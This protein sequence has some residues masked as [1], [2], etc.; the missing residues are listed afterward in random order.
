[1]RIVCVGGGPAGLYVAVLMKRADPTHEITVVERNP[2]GFSHGWGVVF[3]HPLLELLGASDPVTAEE[4]A[5]AAFAW[6]GQDVDVQGRGR[7]S[8]PSGGFSIARQHLLDILTDRARALGVHVDFDRDVSPGEAF[9]ADLVVAADGAN[10]RHR[11]AGGF[12]AQVVAGRNKYVWLATSKVFTSFLFA[13]VE[14]PAG[15]LWCHAYGYDHDRSTVIVECSPTTWRGLGLDRL[16]ARES[17]S[18]LEGLFD[19]HLDGHPLIGPPTEGSAPLPW[20]EFR[21]VRCARWHDRTTVLAGDAAHTTHFAI[22][23]GTA[24]A[25]EDAVA[26]STALIREPDL[27]VALQRYQ[28]QR[29]EALLLSQREA[30]HSATWLEN[31]ERYIDSDIHRFEAL[32]HRRRSALLPHV[33]PGLYVRARQVVEGSHVARQVWQHASAWRRRVYLRRGT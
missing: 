18:L 32:L 11:T 15:W 14:S 25:L 26:L 17:L 20:L 5:G 4:I 19:R 30:H 23:S 10:S 21:T 13:F 28:A 8:R 29:Q 6:E 27:H 31:V 9:G 33:P 1:V 2:A 3:W 12:E 16:G 7:V 24:L 22:G